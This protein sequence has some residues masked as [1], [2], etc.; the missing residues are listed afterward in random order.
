MIPLIEIAEQTQTGEKVEEKTWDMDFFRTISGLVKKY[1]IRTPEHHCYINTD[2]EI[3]ERAF[4]AA[5]EF[6]SR[7]GILVKI[8]F[9]FLKMVK[10][11]NNLYQNGLISLR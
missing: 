10:I 4:H 1:G 11:F 3:A 8:L 6:I 7:M 5:I 2:D 9:E